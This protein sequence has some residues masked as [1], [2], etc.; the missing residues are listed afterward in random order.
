[1]KTDRF[2][3]KIYLIFG[4]F[5][6]FAFAAYF[7]KLIISSEGILPWFAT[8][9]VMAAVAL[10]FIF[11]KKLRKRFGKAYV[12]L[13]AVM[14][15]AFVFYTVTLAALVGYI[16]LSPSAD[17]GS[18]SGRAYV[19][20]GA[21]VK[22]YGVTRTLAARLDSAAEA[23]GSDPDGVIVVSGGRGIDEPT[24][25]AE[26]MRDYLVSRGVAAD[27]ILVEDKAHNTA[28]NIRF[29]VA[30]LKE[31]GRDGMPLVCVSSDTHVPRI[32]LLC[33]REGVEAEYIKAPSPVKKY[34]FTTWVRE[35]LSYGKMLLIGY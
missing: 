12:P 34:L 16:Y 22:D 9:A 28:E 31:E 15:A 19:V 2:L 11:R 21:K 35:Y 4:G 32:R 25:E 3:T 26:A 6:F 24:T 7:L 20:F 17:A 23:L 13:K 29:S 18:A 14:C 27:K 5:V 33:A 10:P 8:T 30:L 1:M